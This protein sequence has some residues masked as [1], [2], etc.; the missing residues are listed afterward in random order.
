MWPGIGLSVVALAVFVAAEYWYQTRTFIAFDENVS[1]RHGRVVTPDFEI[2]LPHYYSIQIEGETYF[3]GPSAPCPDDSVFQSEWTLWKDGRII[4]P[5]DDS[6]LEDRYVSNGP[7]LHGF[8]ADEGRYH[9]DI[10]FLSDPSCANSEGTRLTIQINPWDTD[11]YKSHLAPIEWLMLILAGAGLG[12]ALRAKS[13]P[14]QADDASKDLASR[15][16]EQAKFHHEGDVKPPPGHDGRSLALLGW[17]PLRSLRARGWPGFS[18]RPWERGSTAQFPVTVRNPAKAL[19][20]IALVLVLF[21]LVFWP[22]WVVLVSLRQ[23]PAGMIVRVMGPRTVAGGEFAGETLSVWIDARDRWYFN[24]K[25]TTPEE[26]PGLLRETLA[27]QASQVVY[28]DADD[29]ADFNMVARAIDV[30]RREH[31]QVILITSKR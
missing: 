3:T 4:P 24:S 9:L 5:T 8:N 11:E 13:Q 7:W 18:T 15:L 14:F 29:N 12:M 28:V 23:I 31:A 1:L 20:S 10:N 27:R 21:L 16:A 25:P 30:V 22:A 19:P 2:N 26:L 6:D 17:S